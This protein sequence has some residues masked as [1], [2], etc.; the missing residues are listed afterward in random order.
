VTWSL[1]DHQRKDYRWLHSWL[2]V[3]VRYTLAFTMLDYGLIKVFPMQFGPGLYPGE[4]AVRATGI[5]AVLAR[6]QFAATLAGFAKEGRAIY[7]PYRPAV[8]NLM[9]GTRERQRCKRTIYVS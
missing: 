3:A 5:E 8:C 6:D 2:R 1:A 4:E 9:G 7:T